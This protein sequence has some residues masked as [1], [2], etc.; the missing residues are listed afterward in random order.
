LLWALELEVN[1]AGPTRWNTLDGVDRTDRCFVIEITGCL[2]HEP[3]TSV[4]VPEITPVIRQIDNAGFNA[5]LR[6]G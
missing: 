2:Y 4:G 5:C 1:R 3:T 6:T